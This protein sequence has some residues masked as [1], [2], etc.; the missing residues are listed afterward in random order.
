[1]STLM[2]MA[3]GT[4]GHVYP[5]LSVAHELQSDGVDIF[6][7]GT[8][9]GIEA[10]VVPQ[11]KID[12][13]WISISGIK[14]K[15]LLAL[16][17][18]PLKIIYAMLQTALIIYRRRPQAAL[19]MGGFVSGPG[20]LMAKLLMVPLVIHES[21]A[22]AGLTNKW[23]AKIANEVLVGF[24]DVLRKKHHYHYVGNPVR[25][26]IA[27]LPAP[28]MRLQGR[29]G[30]IHLLIVGGSL[31]AQVLNETVPAALALMDAAVRPVVC[32]QAGKGKLKATSEIYQTLGVEAGCSEYIED[33]A[34]AYQWADLVI[35]RAG[36]MT[37]AEIAAAGV[38][39]IFVPY[40]HAI[41]DHQT[42]NARFLADKKAAIL[43][44]QERFS[45]KT[46]SSLLVELAGDRSSLVA[47]S[48]RARQN[49]LIDATRHVADICN[50]VMHA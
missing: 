38:A 22:V 25:Q 23:L 39:A 4:G 36:A 19:G 21:N 31:G 20:G 47:M 42:H 13:E 30:N 10:R 12:I 50:E 40:P 5:A 11:N 17:A 18:A 9:Q 1:M 26:S 8:R 14:G 49:A 45:D 48:R 27:S 6:W 46:L 44:S 33:M 35:C 7:L 41:Y 43:I 3:G 24:P 29:S 16:I 37:V 34:A 2:I 15:G 32:H 28:D